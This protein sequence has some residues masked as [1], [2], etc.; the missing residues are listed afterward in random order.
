MFREGRDYEIIDN[1][2]TGRPNLSMELFIDNLSIFS[3]NLSTDN[4]P[5]FERKRPIRRGGIACSIDGFRP[6]RKGIVK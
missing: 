6:D 1:L 4:R 3:R 5:I 2:S